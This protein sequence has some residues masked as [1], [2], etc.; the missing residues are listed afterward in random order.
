MCDHRQQA[1]EAQVQFAILDR[2]A[3]KERGHARNKDGDII[4]HRK[5]RK[6]SKKWDV[7]N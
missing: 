1:Y 7:S 2:N 3:H 6:Q 4:Y 5:Y